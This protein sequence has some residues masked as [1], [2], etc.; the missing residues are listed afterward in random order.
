MTSQIIPVDPFDFVV[1]GGTGDLAER[2][3]LPALY[4]RQRD[5]Q[6]SEPTRIIGA[7]RSKMTDEEFRAF[8]ERRSPSTSSRA[9]I[10]AGELEDASWRGCP[11]S[12]VDATTGDGF[13]KLKKALG[14]ER[15]RIRAFYLAVGAGAVRRHLATSSASTSWS[16]RTRASSW[17]SRS[18]A[19]S[20]RRARSTTR[21]ATISRE[22]PDLPH[23]PLSRQG[24]G[25]EPDGAALRQ[26]AVRAAVELRPYRPR[27]DHR[28][29]DASASKAAS[30]TTTR[31][32]RCATWCRTTCC[33][34]SAS[35]R[36]SRRPRWTPTRVRDEKLK[37]LRALKP[38]QR[39]RGAEAHRARPVPRR[40]LGR[41]R[42][43]KGYLEELGKASSS[44]ETFVALKAEIAN[45][46]WAGVPFY[47]RTGKRLA[48]ARVGDRH[49]VQPIPHSIFD[50]SAGRDQRQ[51]AGHPPAA[52]RGRQA[53]DDDQGSRARAACGCATCRST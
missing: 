11:T 50:D 37:V 43:C 36:W 31:P 16:R 21:S 26:R 23:R 42:R 44:T 10:D 32:A 38:H 22:E 53:V 39:R 1:F 35:S 13:D 48:A 19:T 24:D 28:G 4:H 6:F 52:R 45:W 27:A 47:L 29:R 20:P 18:A 41:R 33:S 40:R 7:S 51:P 25:A 9:D 14:D 34:C 30:A 5:H 8:A 17:R 49:R 46:R 15:R 12:P 2:K 3:L